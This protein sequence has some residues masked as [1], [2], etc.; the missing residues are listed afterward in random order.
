VWHANM[1]AMIDLNDRRLA[2]DGMHL[3]ADG[4]RRL[5]AAFV[6]PVL[7]AVQEF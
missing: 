2:Y 5:A 3:T 6:G 7:R 4:N 1:S